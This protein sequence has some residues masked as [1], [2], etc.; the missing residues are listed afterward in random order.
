MGVKQVYHQSHKEEH[1][2]TTLMLEEQQLLRDTARRFAE[3]R[4]APYAREW[5]RQGR[6]PDETIREL[7]KHGLMGIMIPEKYGG[8]GAGYVALAIV[9]EELARHDGG[10]ALALEVHN[11]VCCEHILLAGTPEQHLRFLPPLAR[12]EKIGSWCLSEPNCGSDALAMESKAVR[13]GDGWI[14]NGTKQFVTNATRAG[15]FVVAALTGWEDDRRGVGA[16]VVQAGTPGLTIGKPEEK[17]GM[18]SSD[19]ASIHLDHVRVPANHLL[20]KAG[21]AFSDVKN[22]L[23]AGR[24]MISAVSLGLAR[25]ALEES[26]R[27]ALERKAF[28][29]PIFEFQSIQNKLADMAIHIEAARLLVCHAAERLDEG[30]SCQREAP[31][32]KLFTTEM[33]TR[34]CMDAIQVLGGYGYLREYGVERYMR[35][36]KLCEIAEGTSEIMRVLIARELSHQFA[37]G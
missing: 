37:A 19:T 16:F 24:V 12:G 4:V 26:A 22:A 2:T 8:A 25:G 5:D 28:G 13:K 32:T 7:G 6:F 18:R 36:A 30:L 29:K 1:A 3:E 14:L 10:L 9:L 33:A 35:D 27:Y 17:L 21:E 15:T 31:I 20:G 23:V 34:T 11:A